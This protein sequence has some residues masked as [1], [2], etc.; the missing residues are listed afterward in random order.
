MLR[1]TG[2]KSPSPTPPHKERTKPNETLESI[3]ISY[4]WKIFQCTYI[5]SEK[6]CILFT[7]L[8][9]LSQDSIGKSVSK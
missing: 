9:K 8:S 6:K 4:S 5:V 3:C 2:N 7:L 1:E